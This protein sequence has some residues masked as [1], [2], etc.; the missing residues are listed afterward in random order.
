MGAGALD[1]APLSV[2]YD[3][4]HPLWGGLLLTIHGTGQ[5]EQKAVRQSAGEIVPVAQD[6][7]LDLVRLLLFHDAWVQLV[8]E[9]T[10]LPDES[11]ALLTIR[12]ADEQTT[13]WEWYHDLRV[14]R[15]IIEIR[16]RMQ[17][18][19]WRTSTEPAE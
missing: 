17:E 18:I 19:A 13:I 12:Y 10:L 6:D 5:V 16:D 2:S 3:N 7:V 1:L 9:R 14:N 4:L 11:R 8:P 15:R